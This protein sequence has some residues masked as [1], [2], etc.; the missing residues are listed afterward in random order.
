[1]SA[2]AVLVFLLSLEMQNQSETSMTDTIL[3]VEEKYKR[4]IDER[5]RKLRD[6][7]HKHEE[8]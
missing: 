8:V 1:M 4:L 3:E 6:I 7:V 2:F 5:D